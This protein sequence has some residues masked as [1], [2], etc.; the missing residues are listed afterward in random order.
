[1]VWAALL[2]TMAPLADTLEN[3]V[4]YFMLSEPVDFPDHLAWVYSGFAA[5]KFGA[6][7]FAYVAAIGGL[8]I[9]AIQRW[10]RPG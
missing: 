6:F 4:S 1:M 2:S 5:L 9:G 7:T 8:V 10:H 3:L